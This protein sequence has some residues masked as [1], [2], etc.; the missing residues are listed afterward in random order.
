[1]LLKSVGSILC[2]RCANTLLRWKTNE[3]PKLNYGVCPAAFEFLTPK[4]EKIQNGRRHYIHIKLSTI[5]TI[6]IH[7]TNEER[8]HH[9]SYKHPKQVDGVAEFSSDPFH[10]PLAFFRHITEYSLVE[11]DRLGLLHSKSKVLSFP[12]LYH[13]LPLTQGYLGMTS[14]IDP[15]ELSQSLL[16]T[17]SRPGSGVSSQRCNALS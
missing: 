5:K 15:R 10:Q 8:P 3:C 9:C 11:S 16:M 14:G 6:I 4:M 12:A 13:V 7:R 2:L 17:P 1:M